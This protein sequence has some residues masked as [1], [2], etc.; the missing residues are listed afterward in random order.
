[1]ALLVIVTIDVVEYPVETVVETTGLALHVL[2]EEK[3]LLL[4]LLGLLALLM[5]CWEAAKVI[6]M[7]D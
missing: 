1:V 2:T 7:M 6:V 5:E 3:T 4:C